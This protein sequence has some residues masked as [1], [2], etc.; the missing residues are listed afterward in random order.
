MF[1]GRHKS[2]QIVHTSLVPVRKATYYFWFLDFSSRRLPFPSLLCQF[3]CS[4]WSTC[5]RKR[6][7]HSCSL[8]FCSCPT[9]STDETDCRPLLI[10]V[11]PLDMRLFFG[12][13]SAKVLTP[14]T[15]LAE[16]NE[17]RRDQCTEL[18]DWRWKLCSGIRKTTAWAYDVPDGLDWGYWRNCFFC[19]WQRQR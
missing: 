8:L 6:K 14:A 4:Y 17:H 1:D 18:A 13:C 9:F 10:V 12:S 16:S 3:S 5:R 11:I 7:E 2:Y 19:C 15:F